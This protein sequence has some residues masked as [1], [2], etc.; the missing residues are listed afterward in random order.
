ME[1]W[2][3]TA[4]NGNIKAKSD[5]NQPLFIVVGVETADGGP[6]QGLT[7][8]NFN[9]AAEVAG[10]GLAFSESVAVGDAHLPGFYLVSVKPY[11]GHTWQRGLFV[12]SIVVHSLAARG[13]A[14][15]SCVLN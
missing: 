7:V 6:V 10:S 3:V 5:N 8:Q 14:L 1:K 9:I 15:C 2:T 11:P 13:S 12:F 4:I